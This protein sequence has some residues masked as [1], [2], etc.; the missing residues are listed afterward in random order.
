MIRNATIP[1]GFN[2]V[3][4]FNA[5][6]QDLTA[7]PGFAPVLLPHDEYTALYTHWQLLHS[8][9][10][11]LSEVHPHNGIRHTHSMTRIIARKP[12]HAYST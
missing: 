7:H 10:S 6:H 8:T 1:G 3:C 11:D 9:D 12:K 4:A 5:R 2:V